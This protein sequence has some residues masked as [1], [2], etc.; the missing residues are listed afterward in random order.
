MKDTRR[1]KKA[2][3]R[4]KKVSANHISAKELTFIYIFI[5]SK[6]IKNYNLTAKN[7]QSIKNW[8]KDLNRHFS[9]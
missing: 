3:Y 9:K 7:K 6:Y 1:S 8:A 2:A 4:M 5:Y